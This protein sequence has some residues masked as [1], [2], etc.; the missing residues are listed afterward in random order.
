[1]PTSPVRFQSVIARFAPPSAIDF[2]MAADIE[3]K[4]LLLGD[5]QRQGDSV[6]VGEADA[7]T[8]AEFPAEGMQLQVRLK[9][10]ALQFA[11]HFAK[12]GDEI[13]VFLEETARLAEK[14]LRG[15]D[16]VHQSPSTS[17]ALSR[18]SAVA[19]VVTLPAL[20]SSS[21]VFTRAI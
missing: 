19:K 18:S 4:D 8:T 21:A 5:Q 2:I 3:K 10:I 12:A 20:T 1:M 9:G 7:I 15:D 14:L 13:G 6:A 17:R 16:V 11:D